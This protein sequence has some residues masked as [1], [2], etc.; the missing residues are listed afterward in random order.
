MMQSTPMRTQ[1]ELEGL[2]LPELRALTTEYGASW[3]RTEKK[4]DIIP[5]LIELSSIIQPNEKNLRPKVETQPVKIIPIKLTEEQI[6][7]AIQA[8]IELGLLVRFAKDGSGWQFKFRNHEDSGSLTQP[9]QSIVRCAD[10]LVRGASTMPKCRGCGQ[11]SLIDTDTGYV[12]TNPN[13]SKVYKP[14]GRG[15]AA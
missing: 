10:A 8:S 3:Q 1:E 2:T 11:P 15:A 7:S 12:C 4:A 6:V 5:R 13:C 14:R 9:I